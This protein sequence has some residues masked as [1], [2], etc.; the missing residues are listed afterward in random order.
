[1]GALDSVAHLCLVSN[2]R[3]EVALVEPND[4]ELGRILVTFNVR[5]ELLD[6]AA[7]AAKEGD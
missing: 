5:S 1:M 7:L 6:V 3:V 4:L 2:G